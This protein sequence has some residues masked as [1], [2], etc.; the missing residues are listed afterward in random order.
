MANNNNNSSNNKYWQRRFEKRKTEGLA[1]AEKFNKAMAK[2]YQWILKEVEKDV[3][4]WYRRYARE[5]HMSLA[6]AKKQLR[7]GELKAFKLTLEEFTKLVKQEKLSKE[8]L[9][10]LNKA[11]IRVRLT[12]QEEIYITLSVRVEQ[13]LQTLKQDFRPMLKG[14]YEDSY[15]K[16][17]YEVQSVT[18][19]TNVTRLADENIDTVLKNPWAS[20][21][22]IFSDRIWENQNRL[23]NTL[24]HELAQSLILQEGGAPLVGRI[25]KR[26]N[27]SFNDARRLVETETA[28]IQEQSF[29]D[30]MKGL[31]VKQYQIIATLDNRTSPICRRLDLKIFDLKDAKPGISTP[32]FHVY[33]RSTTV[34]Y[35]EGISDDEEDT[36]AARM[37][38]DGKTHDVNSKLSYD[39]WRRGYVKNG[40]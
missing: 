7:A 16:S 32:P 2:R 3:E 24:R 11:S 26:F 19:Y 18:G 17:M 31:K 5:N 39:E 29:I 38:G 25:Q 23:I 9:D 28:F 36:R 12:R 1:E 15:Y 27:V 14:V 4:Y 30:S 6:D 33:C 20:D 40:R 21:G 13:A 8:V 22:K 37:G 35:I 10:M 34:P